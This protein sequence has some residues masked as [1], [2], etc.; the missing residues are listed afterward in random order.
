M[1]P[2]FLGSIH[3]RRNLMSSII[4]IRSEER[5]V[6]NAHW[7]SEYPAVFDR[8]IV[9]PCTKPP[10]DSEMEDFNDVK[11][12]MLE[13]ELEFREDDK[14][15]NFTQDFLSQVRLRTSLSWDCRLTI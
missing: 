11:N 5:E 15:S 8:N 13:T 3:R 10:L 6:P 1:P 4:Q 14:V 2:P 7:Q 9:D 12:E